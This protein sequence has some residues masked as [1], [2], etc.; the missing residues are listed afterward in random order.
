VCSVNHRKRQGLSGQ[1]QDLRK[2]RPGRH[3]RLEEELKNVKKLTGKARANEEK[4]IR[5]R[6]ICDTYKKIQKLVKISPQAENEGCIRKVGQE[7]NHPSMNLNLKKREKGR[8]S[9]T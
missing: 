1:N 6:E 4:Q 5:K 2:E 7:G 3:K 9:Q 8:L